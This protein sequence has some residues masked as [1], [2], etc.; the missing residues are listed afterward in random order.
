MDNKGIQY[1]L[2]F[3]DY[4]KSDGLSYSQLKYLVKCPKNFKYFVL[5][6]NE[7]TDTEAMKIGRAFHTLVLEPH[8][9]EKQYYI[10][11]KIRRAGQAWDEM[12]ITAGNRD[13]I[14]T[15]DYNELNYMNQSIKKHPYASKL[16]TD[17]VNEV[18]I[19]WEHKVSDDTK[20]LCRSRID[21][22]KNITNQTALIDIKTT[23][24]ISEKAF[25]KTIFNFKYHMQAA[26]YLDAYKYVNN[27]L[28]KSFIF[29]AIE[30]TAPYLCA[31]YVLPSNGEAIELGRA[32]YRGLLK[33]YALCQSEE[34]W[35]EGFDKPIDVYVPNWYK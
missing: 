5:D 11:N 23:L 6:A 25:I 27:K 4:L 21:A 7:K 34:L 22:I 28:P 13:I 33:K 24:D 18:S 29:I 10:A 32:E 30:K 3:D 19:F 16:L 15:E 2:S 9:F 31:I 35:N 12:Q 17:S 20:L 14:W 8:L 1:A 26:F